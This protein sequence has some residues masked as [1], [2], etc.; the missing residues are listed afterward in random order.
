MGTGIGSRINA[1][2]GGMAEARLSQGRQ[3]TLETDKA[4]LHECEC[5]TEL[6]IKTPVR[7]ES[8]RTG[9]GGV[10]WGIGVYL[11]WLRIL[12]PDIL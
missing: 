8:G 6:G 9:W 10:G 5:S 11:I 1:D 2:V 12:T 7:C 3:D 4:V